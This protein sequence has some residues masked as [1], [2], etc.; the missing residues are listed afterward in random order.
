MDVRK[1]RT[2]FHTA[3]DKRQVVHLSQFVERLQE[4]R[5]SYQFYY[6][7]TDQFLLMGNQSQ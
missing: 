4:L 7:D 3:G 5:T 6:V 1:A 2:Y